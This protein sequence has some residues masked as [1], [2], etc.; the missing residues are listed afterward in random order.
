[1]QNQILKFLEEN[2]KPY[3]TTEIAVHVKGDKVQVLQILTELAENEYVA[4]STV[5]CCEYW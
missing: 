1:M 3:N 2:K 5:A 4:H